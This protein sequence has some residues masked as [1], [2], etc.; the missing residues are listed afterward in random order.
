MRA[1]AFTLLEIMVSVVVLTILIVLVSRIV[2]SASTITTLG[3]K[4]MDSDTQARLVFDRMAIDFAQMIKRSDVDA[5]VKGT[6]PENGNDRIAFFSQIPG[7]YPSPSYQSPISLIAY[8]INALAGSSSF[9]GMERMGKGLM[10][11]GISSSYKPLLFG[12]PPTVSPAPLTTNWPGA[13]TGDPTNVDYTDPDFQLV[14]PQIFR[15]EYFYLMK[16]GMLAHTPPGP[17]MQDVAAVCVDIASID[18]KSRV[19]L[20]DNQIATLI[21]SLA[22]FPNPPSAQAKI[23]DLATSWQAT[24]DGIPGT[25]MPRPAINGIRIY[26]RTFYLSPVK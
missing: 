13:T 6:D 20:S 12:A 15:F 10:W 8:R 25:Q 22:D 26:Q 5:Y 23:S 4:R 14:G 7:Y 17:G 3:N 1:R 9:N 21:G 2:G 24:L 11:H 16:T 18:P 19:L